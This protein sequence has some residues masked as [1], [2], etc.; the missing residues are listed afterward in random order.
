ML[1]KTSSKTTYSVILE[2]QD[3]KIGFGLV[4]KE[5]MKAE[6]FNIALQ[7][8]RKYV[9]FCLLFGIISLTNIQGC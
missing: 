2:Y 7:S 6:E 8:F 1:Q 3:K 4:F 9:I 5:P